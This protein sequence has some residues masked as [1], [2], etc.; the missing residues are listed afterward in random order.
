MSFLSI[1]QL[2]LFALLFPI[3]CLVW[4]YIN[5]KKVIH[6]IIEKFEAEMFVNQKLKCCNCRLSE[7]KLICC[8]S[9]DNNCLF[10]TVF[11]LL[12]SQPLIKQYKKKYDYALVKCNS[13]KFLRIQ[14]RL[15]IYN[16]ANQKA[17]F[18]LDKYCW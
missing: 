9:N 8:K 16:V 12:T 2:F 15:H 14:T 5:E 4:F 6:E 10:Y 17:L 3:C 18:F 13:K 1:A 11:A 7:K